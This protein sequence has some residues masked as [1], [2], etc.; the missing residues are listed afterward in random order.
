MFL[1]FYILFS[2]PLHVGCVSNSIGIYCLGSFFLNI[3]WQFLRALN[4]VPIMDPQV[5]SQS[6]FRR[7]TRHLS[8]LWLNIVDLRKFLDRMTCTF[9][10][11]VC[12]CS[13]YVDNMN[14]QTYIEERSV[15]TWSN[16][17]NFL[18]KRNTF[19]LGFL[20]T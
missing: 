2:F 11:A 6:A 4:H 16:N 14:P 7:E 13:K 3:F 20:L 8:V 12:T 18:I 10:H 5:L 19:K 1:F 17:F 15:Y 9:V